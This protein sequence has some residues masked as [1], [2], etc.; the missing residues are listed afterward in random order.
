MAAQFQTEL[1]AMQSMLQ[2]QR[3]MLADGDWQKIVSC[4]SVVFANRAKALTL[5]A[6][7][8]Q[9]L[10]DLVNTGPW[11]SQQK[12][13]LAL[14]LCESLS[15]SASSASIKYE[16]RAVQ[17]LRHFQYYCSAPEAQLIIDPEKPM[18]VK[19]DTV[20]NRLSLLGCILPSCQ[21][22]KHILSVILAASGN[23]TDPVKI[24]SWYLELRGAIHSRF[25][26]CKDPGPVGYCVQFPEHPKYMDETARKIAY[27][28]GPP[29]DMEVS[30][31]SI[32]SVSRLIALRKN[33]QLLQTARVQ[34]VPQ[35]DQAIVPS[36]GPAD[37][38]HA[39][40]SS[41]LLQACLRQ[42]SL[43]QGQQQPA[44]YI[45][46]LDRSAAG[47]VATPQPLQPS[48]FSQRAAL[49]LT[50]KLPNDSPSKVDAVE[51]CSP[52]DQANRFLTALGTK[53]TATGDD[54]EDA[55]LEDD[56]TD[57]MPNAKAT[58]KAKAKAKGSGCAKKP[59]A[60]SSAGKTK[61]AACAKATAND[62][63]GKAPQADKDAKKRPAAAL[64]MVEL[65][66]GCSRCRWGKGGCATCRDPAFNG[67]RGSP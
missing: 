54:D 33:S 7:T 22:M 37:P 23:T 34:G 28:G 41:N 44:P 30:D 21:T 3:G 61:G 17:E 39:F 9:S 38:M 5:D 63:A 42:M 67:R 2:A 32:A 12:G 52:Q 31:A 8:I 64:S 29:V 11:S 50:D 58:A 66:L 51:Q 6:G 45:Q 25:R 16:Q 62:L 49:P 27:A 24:R 65:V 20:V 10:T 15:G 40:L 59:A 4:Q 53:S 26:N 46:V 47:P 1:A 18:V 19:I 55:S 35:Q 43:Q 60:K 48:A 13:D 57:T 14:A 36:G 56:D